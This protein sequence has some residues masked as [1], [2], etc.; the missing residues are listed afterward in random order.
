MAYQ[1]S[2]GRSIH[3]WCL[4]RIHTAGSQ[5]LFMFFCSKGNQI[6]GLQASCNATS[7]GSAARIVGPLSSTLTLVRLNRM[8]NNI[9][10]SVSPF[11]IPVLGGPNVLVTVF[12]VLFSCL[13]SCFCRRSVL[14]AVFVDVQFA[15]LNGCQVHEQ[16]ADAAI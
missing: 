4:S 5:M 8:S 6:P 3:P 1:P 2:I 16:F 15:D 14:R 13:S 7:M 11:G 9:T 10:I 12:A